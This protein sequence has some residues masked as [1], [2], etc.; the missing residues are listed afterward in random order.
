MLPPSWSCSSYRITIANAN[1]HFANRNQTILFF[2]PRCDNIDIN[3]RNSRWLHDD[4][5]LIHCARNLLSHRGGGGALFKEHLSGAVPVQ[6]FI[7]TMS[8][9]IYYWNN[10]VYGLGRTCLNTPVGY[11]GCW[12]IDIVCCWLRSNIYN[13]FI[14]IYKFQLAI[15]WSLGFNWWL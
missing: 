14:F 15:V 9:H 7:F 10:D 6:Q 11:C 1:N 3:R 12:G 2:Q 13:V 5:G 8:Q 4:K